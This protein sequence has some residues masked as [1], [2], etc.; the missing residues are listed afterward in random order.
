MMPNANL[1]G[2]QPPPEMTLGLP[3]QPYTKPDNFKYIPYPEPLPAP[4][5]SWQDR[6]GNAVSLA[7]LKGYVVLINFWATWCGPCVMEMPEL[8]SLQQRY[9]GAGLLVAAVSMDEGGLT[10]IENFYLKH[11]IRNL[12]VFSDTEAAGPAAFNVRTL[13]S[14]FLINRD[15]LLIGTL[16]GYGE[17]L[18]DS[19]RKVI[20]DALRQGA[21]HAPQAPD[22]KN[23]EILDIVP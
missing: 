9:G 12:P 14:S 16:P 4:A 2:W 17:W 10:V 15:G 6:Q 7:D 18:S 3:D 1:M 19:A 11:K 5:I 8:D 23:V 20:E 22:F 13:P 21:I